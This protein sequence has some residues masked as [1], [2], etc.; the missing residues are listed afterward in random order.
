M[1][2]ADSD[3]LG[4]MIIWA[5][6]FEFSNNFQETFNELEKKFMFCGE[7]NGILSVVS[8]KG[9]T[10]IIKRSKIRLD[11]IHCNIRVVKF[12]MLGICSHSC[13]VDAID[14]VIR[15]RAL[16]TCCLS[17]CLLSVSR[18]GIYLTRF[19]RMIVM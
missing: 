4:K 19:E 6:I 12:A 17:W 1:N 5:L 15:V 10:N 9:L 11:N 16:M 7:S 13:R 2:E 18:S 14:R 3:S 8:R